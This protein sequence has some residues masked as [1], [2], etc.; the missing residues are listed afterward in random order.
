M[1]PEDGAVM[2]DQYKTDQEMGEVDITEWHRNGGIA[3]V[4]NRRDSLAKRV[5]GVCVHACVWRE[6]E[7]A[8]KLSR[9]LDKR[10]RGTEANASCSE[11]SYGGSDV[12]RLVLR[13]IDCSSGCRHSFIA[14]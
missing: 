6:A 11:E 9:V 13:V 10:D 1:S 12:S 8:L 14:D 3:G 5:I 4:F 2:N 7:H